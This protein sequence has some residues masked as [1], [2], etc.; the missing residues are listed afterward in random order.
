MDETKPIETSCGFFGTLFCQDGKNLNE[1]DTLDHIASIPEGRQDIKK[2]NTFYWIGFGTWLAGVIVA[3]TAWNV[4]QSTGQSQTQGL[5]GVGMMLASIPFN[6][7]YIEKLYDGADVWN[8]QLKSERNK[9]VETKSIES[10]SIEAKTTLSPFL[11]PLIDS[12]TTGAVA[13]LNLSF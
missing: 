2:A 7:L 11:V 10:S 9:S 1:D 13:G 5:V 12:Q 6:A 8:R 3:E 4:D